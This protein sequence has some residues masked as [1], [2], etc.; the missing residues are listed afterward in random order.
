M[1][2]VRPIFL[3]RCSLPR[4][5]TIP[6]EADQSALHDSLTACQRAVLLPLRKGSAGRSVQASIRDDRRRRGSPC[7]INAPA[8]MVGDRVSADQHRITAIF[9]STTLLRSAET[10]LPC[11]C[12][13]RSAPMPNSWRTGC[14]S[15]RGTAGAPRLPHRRAGAGHGI[16]RR[17][18]SALDRFDYPRGSDRSAGGGRGPP[19]QGR[20]SQPRRARGDR[21]GDH[22]TRRA[23]A[24]P[25]D[26]VLVLVLLF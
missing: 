17:A 12:R 9:A 10:P 4:C 3:D 18:D 25:D 19:R 21:R 7:R 8:R 13:K 1:A 11:C 16:G 14:A 22:S 26:L 23:T 20:G 24:L 6:P 5:R 15:D 2:G